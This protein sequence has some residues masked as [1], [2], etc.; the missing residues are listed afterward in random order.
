MSKAWERLESNEIHAFSYSAEIVKTSA[1]VFLFNPELPDVQ[2]NRAMSLRL[3]EKFPEAAI[4]EFAR[5]FV[6][7]GQ[8][9]AFVVTPMTRPETVG[10]VLLEQGYSPA[11]RVA[12]M[13]YG[14]RGDLP[15]GNGVTIKAC[16]SDDAAEWN[17]AY[18]SGSGFPAGL[19]EPLLRRMRPAF[20]RPEFTFYLA[21]G[22]GRTLG[23]ATR[24]SRGGIAGIYN[25]TI[26]AE[27]RSGGVAGA[28]LA[29][30]VEDH[31]ASGDES[32]AAP[33][34]EGSGT[35]A[36]LERAWF[37]VAFHQEWYRPTGTN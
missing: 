24:F 10:K 1:A 30:A 2:F 4:E 11:F 18:C 8:T 36:L 16:T 17:R 37:Q 7:R 12:V 6:A 34:L 29:R 26:V 21:V 20:S 22:G 25:V 27:G 33:V 31:E 15:P 35:Q 19:A 9:P 5:M 28:L 23:T 14:G 32:L 13:A 3:S